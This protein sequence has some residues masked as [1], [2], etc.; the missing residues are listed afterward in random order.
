MKWNHKRFKGMM[1]IGLS[2]SVALSIMGVQP[3]SAAMA[4][5]TGKKPVPDASVLAFP[6]A[7]GGGAYATG[8]RG[9][10]V[11]IVT[12]LDD[13]KENE[14]PIA[15]SLRYGILST[16]QEGRTI[17]FHV[18][19]TIEL[20][21]SLRLNNIK[22]FDDSWSNCTWKRHYHCRLGYEHQQFREH[23]HPLPILPTGCCK[24]I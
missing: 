16:P 7:E 9:G 5:E 14:E 13:Y 19:G 22:K 12:N 11:Y 21:S 4:L 2:F 10:D 15:G 1:S 20:E 8:G 6:G 18:S 17:V 24:C 3:P 23:H